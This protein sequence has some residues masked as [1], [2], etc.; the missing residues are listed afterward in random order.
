MNTYCPRCFALANEQF[1][2]HCG[3]DLEQI[4]KLRT[5]EKLA[6]QRHTQATLQEVLRVYQQ[7]GQPA[8]V[9]RLLGQLAAHS[10]AQG[11]WGQAYQTYL[12]LLTLEDSAG[13][14]AF[15]AGIKTQLGL[16]VGRRGELPLAHHLLGQAE[17]AH[18]PQA[19]LAQLRLEMDER[20]KAQVNRR[21]AT[22][23]GHP[24][25]EAP[26][27]V[28][29]ARIR[30]NTVENADDLKLLLANSEA[31]SLVFALASRAWGLWLTAHQQ[32]QAALEHLQAA[33]QTF[34]ALQDPYERAR[35]LLD[36]ARAQLLAA[37]IG[38][39]TLRYRETRSR[40][41]DA[42][43]SQAYRHLGLAL[44]LF[45]HLGTPLL[46]RQA[47]ELAEALHWGDT[48]YR[49]QPP[50]A[51]ESPTIPF[52]PTACGILWLALDGP[53][54][55]A[56]RTQAEEV[57]QRQ[58]G[59]SARL[60]GG[61]AV[62]FPKPSWATVIETALALHDL[63]NA[64]ALPARARFRLNVSLTLLHLHPYDWGHSLRQMEQSSSFHQ[65]RQ[66]KPKHSPGQ[67]WVGAALYRHTQADYRYD[68]S[69]QPQHWMIL[70]TPQAVPARAPAK[71]RT[72]LGGEDPWV[73]PLAPLL[74]NFKMRR[75]GGVIGIEG[76][77]GTGKT[78]LLDWLIEEGKHGH[79]AWLI[80]LHCREATR[81]EPFG[82]I[83]H[84]LG[85]DF[86]P[87]VSTAEERH[88]SHLATFR[89]SVVGLL[90]SRPLILAVDD[91]H[92]LDSGS[93]EALR[94]ILP[95][96]A[97]H[98]LLVIL[99]ARPPQRDQA[100][101][102]AAAES[103]RDLLELASRALLDDCRSVYLANEVAYQMP[104]LPSDSDL[105]HVLFSA[106]V[107]GDHFTPLVLRRM[108]RAAHLDRHLRALQTQGWLTPDDTTLRWRFSHTAGRDAVYEKIAP[109]YRALLHWE[110]RQAL[111]YFGHNPNDHIHPSGLSDPALA[112]NMR[113][114]QEALQLDAPYEA[115]LH[116]NRALQ[117]YQGQ[118]TL[119]GLSLGKVT[120]L[121]SLNRLSEAQSLLDDLKRLP[122]LSTHDEA[123]LL[124]V[125]G[126]IYYRVGEIA[127]LFHIYDQAAIKLRHSED[128]DLGEQISLVYAQALARFKRNELEM[129]R[130]MIGWALMMASGA[131]LEDDLADFWELIA[132]IHH[133][134]GEIEPAKAA[135]QKA[136]ASYRKS[137]VHW[138]LVKPLQHYGRLLLE[139]GHLEAAQQ[140]LKDALE[141]A[142]GIGDAL[143]ISSLNHALGQLAL[144]RGEFGRLTTHLQA[145]LT[146]ILFSQTTVEIA[147]ARAALADGLT[148][149]GRLVPALQQAT[150][151]LHLAEQSHD[152]LAILTAQL[153]I[154][155]VTLALN[156]P[157]DADRALKQAELHLPL[158]SQVSLALRCELALV[159]MQW[160]MQQNDSESFLATWEASRRL[161][162]GPSEAFLRGR[163]N[164]LVGQFKAAAGEWNDAA[165]EFE[166]AAALFQEL[167]ALYWA[168]TAKAHLQKIA[169]HAPGRAQTGRYHLRGDAA[170]REGTDDS[171]P[172]GAE[173]ANA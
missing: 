159:R 106:A 3:S 167:G 82:A 162:L 166:R 71:R 127:P 138:L 108:S 168:R 144:Y 98:P 25:P 40:R 59:L 154:A 83:R 28:W 132:Q 104:A 87:P 29:E 66:T 164:L 90:N 173:P 120:A 27:W 125:Q 89:R 112:I 54:E 81:H 77:P 34:E 146:A 135:I 86:V 110:A 55:E 84:W 45:R 21:L 99:T 50:P 100:E 96:T 143:T 156:C 137:G 5:L 30:F 103:W 172:H 38:W 115:L 80:H 58:G 131:G 124:L 6:E 128:S 72:F 122:D 158:I 41:D 126:E 88:L 93:L 117:H 155:R 78:R 33:L 85:E 31:G 129:A 140:P 142:E 44:S 76:L 149:E 57:A 47:A 161:P 92:L 2:P 113:R 42:F 139:S 43:L 116:F 67:I 141:L 118:E 52:A 64:Q 32:P 46:E 123:Q 13:S 62:L 171:A 56:I 152:R 36:M 68:P 136:L 65:L 114:A 74:D 48:Y 169:P 101:P 148:L 19:S 35:T 22:L 73:K 51:S 16:L 63:L 160:A 145:A 170:A 151:A 37:L 17:A 18:D 102:S 165:R 14:P 8:A 39:P 107:L 157:D 24:L 7:L 119:L 53:W 121:L 9:G 69:P 97:S 79:K 70:A 26:A 133:Q 1:C 163:R 91:A 49:L 20:A 109:A 111:K 134:R 10:L 130:S 12:A 95:L 61:L 4:K 75:K 147:Q 105:R 23:E 60:L 11:Q 150:L 94:A 15:V 153:S